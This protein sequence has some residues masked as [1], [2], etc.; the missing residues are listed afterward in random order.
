MHHEDVSQRAFDEDLQRTL[1]LAS[2]IADSIC[3]G[4]SEGQVA[5]RDYTDRAAEWFGL[6]RSA[7]LGLLQSIS[8]HASELSQMFSLNT[9]NDADIDALLEEADQIRRTQKI[10]TTNE[11][12][13]IP[14]DPW[15]SLGERDEID[16]IIRST[17]EKHEDVGLI[18]VGVD[19]MRDLNREAGTKTGDLAMRRAAES[20]VRACKEAAGESAEVYRFVGAEMAVVLRGPIANASITL[21]ER[22]RVAVRLSPLS[23]ESIGMRALTASIGVATMGPT[24]G[25]STP[26][27]LVRAAMVALSEARRRGGD[28]VADSNDPEI[29]ERMA[30]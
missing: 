2:M 20:I 4:A 14:N 1:R 16:V 18:L 21:A 29:N 12:T 8:D 10:A 30:A 25:P 27:E 6:R 23:D 26:D 9:G 17:C 28:A 5:L 11:S 7:A 15:R 3:A 19:N 24:S 22:I 13:D